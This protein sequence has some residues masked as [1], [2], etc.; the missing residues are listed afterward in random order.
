MNYMHGGDHFPARWEIEEFLGD[1]YRSDKHISSRTGEQT[2]DE[3]AEEIGKQLSNIPLNG[4]LTRPIKTTDKPVAS[5]T[6]RP[7]SVSSI[8]S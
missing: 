2:P 6:D 5:C 1:E 7:F 8:A 4:Q 3:I